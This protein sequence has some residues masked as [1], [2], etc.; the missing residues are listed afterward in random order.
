VIRDQYDVIVVG[1]GPAGTMAAW[2]A[3]QGGALVLLLEK[4]RDLGLPVRCAEAVGRVSMDRFLAPDPKWVA[5]ALSH[6]KLVAPNGNVAEIH[7]DEVGYVL[8][9]RIFDQELGR[10][11]AQAGASLLT[12]AYVNGLRKHGEQ[13]TGVRVHLPD[14]EVEIGARVVIGADGVESRVGRWAGLRTWFAPKDFESCYQVLL[15]G[16]E[17]DPN[18]VACYFGQQVAPG[19]YAWVFPKGPDVANVGIGVNSALT[20]GKSAKQWLELFLEKNFPKAAILACVAGGVPA[21]KPFKQIHGPGVLLAGDAAAH[22]NPLTGGGII[23]AM[24]AG[25]LAGSVAAVCIQKGD[26]SLKALSNYTRLWEERWGDEQRRYYRLKEAVCKLTDKIFN[27][28][29]EILNRLP[30]NERTMQSVFRVTLA[31]NP[32]LILD[33]ARSFL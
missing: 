28:A 10:R 3:A 9:R 18:F 11:A 5:H 21:A 19:G 20:N 16:L 29:A 31:H 32:K 30:Q 2:E 1:G 13:V 8:N 27:Q 24:A 14:R 17:V 25:K 4:D 12:R 6:V 7:T 26:W 33:I 15:G 22:S 23:S